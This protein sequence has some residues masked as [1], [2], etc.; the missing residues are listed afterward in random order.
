VLRGSELAGA[1]VYFGLK[2]DSRIIASLLTA[3]R[4]E[5]T[6][7]TGVHRVGVTCYA[8]F[9]WRGNEL[10]SHFEAD[11]HRYFVLRGELSSCAISELDPNSDE[12]SELQKDSL[13]VPVGTQGPP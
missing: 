1:G 10:S 5:F 12:F 2:L 8:W 11:S 7:S 9:K 4:T 6:V 13:L 3:Q